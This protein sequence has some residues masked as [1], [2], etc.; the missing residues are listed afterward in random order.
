MET[1]EIPAAQSR[2]LQPAAVRALAERGFRAYFEAPTAYV[3]LFVFYLL[4]GYFFTVPLFFVNQASIKGFSDYL[5]L[6]FCFLVPALTMGLLAE[7]IKSGTFETLATLPLEDWDIVLG[8]FL[9]FGAAHAVT[10]AGLGVYPLA[11]SLLVAPPAG[12]DWG[13]TGGVLLGLV[14][15]GLMFGAAG[16]FASSLSRSQIISFVT[17]FLLCFLI[18]AIGKASHFAPGP[19][20]RVLEFVGSDAHLETMA[21]GV[22]DTR[23]LLYFASAT[24]GFLYLT[25]QRL[26]GRKF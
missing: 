15:L 6:L 26:H 22:V 24:F 12:L 17:A 14:L 3:V 4:A 10:V 25:V 8:K 5:P 20:G 9:G 21:K 23:D 19:A 7:E 2:L 13:E 1:I 16:L 18:F 11:L